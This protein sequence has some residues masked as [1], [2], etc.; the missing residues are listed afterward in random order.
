MDR[1]NFLQAV[2]A[3]VASPAILSSLPVAPF[4][5]DPSKHYGG[6]VKVTDFANETVEEA[7]L[8]IMRE[9]RSFLPTGTRFEII[10]RPLG[11]CGSD[12]PFNEYGS[13]GWKYSPKYRAGSI[14]M[15]A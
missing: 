14:L 13:V 10:E 12:D 2:A 15:T 9:A 5:F 8:L 6:F 4:S 11:S 3:F 1:R 7:W